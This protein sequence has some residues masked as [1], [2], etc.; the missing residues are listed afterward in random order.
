MPTHEIH[1]RRRVTIVKRPLIRRMYPLHII[2]R[3][4]K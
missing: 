4:P 1:D 3:Q 2:K